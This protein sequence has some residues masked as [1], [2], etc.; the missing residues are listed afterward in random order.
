[1]LKITENQI[2]RMYMKPIL[3]S[4]ENRVT[5]TYRP[6]GSQES[7]SITLV[8]ASP[9][10]LVALCPQKP[11]LRGTISYRGLEVEVHLKESKRH[12][13]HEFSTFS[14]VEGDQFYV[15]LLK[16]LSPEELTTWLIELPSLSNQ[17]AINTVEKIDHEGEGLPLPSKDF[18]RHLESVLLLFFN[19]PWI[20]IFL[21]II[22]SLFPAYHIRELKFDA[23]LDRV[24][25]HGTPIMK[26]YI[27]STKLFGGDKTALIY[28]QDRNI[29]SKEKL[30]KI[31]NL[32]WEL[33][34]VKNV[35]RVRSVFT[36]P[37]IHFNKKE[38]TLYTEPLFSELDIGPEELSQ[39][40]LD[41]QEDPNLHGRLID[42]PKNT[43]VIVLEMSKDITNL[44]PIAEKLEPHIKTLK[45]DF[46]TIFQS[47]E[48]S[49]ELF[50]KEEMS[51]TPK[52]FLPLI[53]LVL[54]VCFVIFLGSNAAFVI[55][56]FT[57]GVSTLWAFGWMTYLDI[58]VQILVNIVPGIILTLSATEI[59]HISSSLKEAAHR[60]L[61]DADSLR[62]VSRDIGKALILTFST[63][64][65]G[66]LSIR[67]SEIQML[68]EFAIV[69]TMGLVFA[70]TVTILY[71]PLHLKF[72]GNKIRDPKGK[73]LFKS[74]KAFFSAIYYNLIFSKVPAIFILLF[75]IVNA[76][77]ALNVEVDNDTFAMITNRTQVK[78]DL[79]KFKEEIGG[80]KNI[81]IVF[82][83]NDQKKA[84]GAK[85]SQTSYLK[86]LWEIHREL[87]AFREVEDVD[88]FS[89]LISLLNQEMHD[90]NKSY[91]RIPDEQ[92]L[93]DQYS[94]LLSRD[95]LDPLITSDKQRANIKFTHDL[96]SSKATEAF[97]QRLKNF[98]DQKLKDKPVK[99]Y[100]T[101]RNI[102]NLY[103]ANTM[104]ESQTSSLLSMGLVIVLLMW[105]FF[106]SLKTGLLSLLP[107]LFPI[108]GLFG[109][110]GI[111]NIP[112]NIGTCIIATIT[113][114][115]AADDTIHLFTRYFRDKELTYNPITTSQL[116]ISDE[117]VPI[118]TT[119]LSLAL[120]FSFFAFARFVPMIYFGL[121]SAYVL[122]LAVISDL[123]LGPAILSNFFF[124]EEK[125]RGHMAWMLIQSHHF[126][127]GAVFENMDLNEVNE[128]LKSGKIVATRK[129]QVG[130]NS[131]LFVPLKD[132]S[133]HV[134]LVLPEEKFQVLSPRTFEKICHNLKMT[135]L[136]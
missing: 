83:F 94:L 109:I 12:G 56:I 60:S 92:P 81:H 69:S 35:S 36:T 113:I 46:D 106:K 73:N 28:F 27:D 58:P 93:I 125:S 122:I 96:S 64:S 124:T 88:S 89:G 78:K 19:K 22:L 102:L 53:T 37:F 25:V 62:F 134:Y 4:P 119:S 52:I 66:F 114:G 61:K 41:V 11:F 67:L 99:Y 84:E 85:F 131:T 104:V 105:M 136:S 50:Q 133:S 40:L 77:F 2:H 57:T 126:Q 44:I 87:K 80:T 26:Q 108:F 111:M 54:L 112:L 30:S 117:V 68:Q 76:Y 100:F 135:N 65:L 34:T 63:T 74:S 90:G 71:L 128:L 103:A 49:L 72:F 29:F 129:S 110:M 5:V 79:L 7:F 14:L 32:A 82:D 9:L 16:G 8:E 75:L 95:E 51:W 33:Q 1:M 118:L 86:L 123:Y 98:L 23:S 38:D 132:S 45:K 55:T 24:M 6:L 116:T 107:N 130:K 13:E 127:K 91:Y 20:S 121:L 43:I 48:P 39:K 97:V 17:E 15:N 101:S 115:I 18:T 70:F 120:S 31:Q 21:L 42:V 3:F 10:K 59:V 47:G